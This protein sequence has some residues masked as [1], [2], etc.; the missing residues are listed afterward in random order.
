MQD[1]IRPR[2]ATCVH[3]SSC[4]PSALPGDAEKEMASILIEDLLVFNG[5]MLAKQTRVP[6]KLFVV[7]SGAFKSEAPLSAGARRV[8]GL[9]EAGD[10]MSTEPTLG[11]LPAAE[12]VALRNS[13]ICVVDP[14]KLQ[15]LAA[16]HPALGSFIM[17]ITA[18]ALVR[19][20]QTLFALGSLHASGR[21]AW[22]LLDLS[23]RRRR[24]GLDP[25]A[26]SV[27]LSGKDIGNHL[28]LRPET[29]S[30]GWGAM[31][32]SGLIS[33]H[34]QD[35]QLLNLDRLAAQASGRDVGA[36]A[37]NASVERTTR[38]KR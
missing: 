38:S 20:Q 17:R 35:V 36:P 2:C 21:L 10:F 12:W 33:R 8:L 13:A 1:S 30:R 6:G 32:R 11:G 37:R 34:G 22:F 16:N 7:R 24:R 29:V 27:P 14:W 28:G 5:E 23:E 9:H 4:L 25:F 3:R 15:A 31:E 18:N 19:A 26:L